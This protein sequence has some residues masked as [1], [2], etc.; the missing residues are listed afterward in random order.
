MAFGVDRYPN[1]PQY[2]ET[3]VYYEMEDGVMVRRVERE[4]EE[5]EEKE[6]DK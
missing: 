3:V 4:E 6:R 1:P 5:E 2:S